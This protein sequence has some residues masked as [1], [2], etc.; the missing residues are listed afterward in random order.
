M[1]N[2]AAALYVNRTFYFIS[3]MKKIDKN[4]DGTKKEEISSNEANLNWQR[5]AATM[6]KVR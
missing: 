2:Q 5:L 4:L 3:L 6:K 1:P